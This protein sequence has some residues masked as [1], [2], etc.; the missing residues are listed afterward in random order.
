MKLPPQTHSEEEATGT[1]FAIVLE[2][3]SDKWQMN[4]LQI[5]GCPTRVKVVVDGY[6]TVDAPAISLTA[7]QA[8]H[9]AT[10]ITE[11]LGLETTNLS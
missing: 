11:I 2:G 8:R 6:G 10:Q 9:L 4:L 5:R 1:A 7:N 3:V